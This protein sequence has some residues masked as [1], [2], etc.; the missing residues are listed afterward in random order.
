MKSGA[1]TFLPDQGLAPGAPG[2]AVEERPLDS[3]LIAEYT[4]PCRPGAQCRA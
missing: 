2:R 3:L 4:H 1:S